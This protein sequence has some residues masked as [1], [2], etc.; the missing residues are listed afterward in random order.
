MGIWSVDAASH[1]STD[2]ASD[3]YADATSD[4]NTDATANEIVDA[5]TTYVLGISS[6]G[7][8]TNALGVCSMAD[9]ATSIT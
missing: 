7:A 6:Y 2:V 9:T 8:V 3:A 5:A 1:D 4:A